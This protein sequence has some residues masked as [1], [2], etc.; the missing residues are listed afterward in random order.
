M[1]ESRLN[2]SARRR[3]VARRSFA[4]ERSGEDDDLRGFGQPVCVLADA[5]FM[6]GV[7][8]RETGG[9]PREISPPRMSERACE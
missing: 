2:D 9:R 4:P 7:E 3:P 1:T 8:A 6:C 5:M